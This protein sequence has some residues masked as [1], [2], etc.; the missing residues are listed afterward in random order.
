[1]GAEDH[2][3]A[4]GSPPPPPIRM[5]FSRWDRRR[6]ETPGNPRC[7]GDVLPGERKVLLQ[8]AFHQLLA[9]PERS[10]PECRHG[11]FQGEQQCADPVQHHRGLNSGEREVVERLGDEVLPSGHPEHHPDT[12]GGVTDLSALQVAHGQGAQQSLDHV[13]ALIRRRRVVH[14]G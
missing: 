1:M 13:E 6:S 11:G 12:S 5:T 14:R 9:T 10:T 2:R 3:L 7:A 8:A 4:N